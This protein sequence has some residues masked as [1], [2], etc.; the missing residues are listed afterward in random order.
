ME[1]MIRGYSVKQQLNFLQTQY[2]PEVSSRL[3]ATIPVE[4]RAELHDLKAAEWYPRAY[5]IA[6]LRAIASHQGNDEQQV[7]NDLARCGMFIATEA[8]NTFLKLLMKILTPTLFAKKIPEFWK[9][10]QTGGHFEVDTSEAKDGRLK[11]ELCDVEGF[12]HIGVIGIGWISFGLT[13]MGKSNVVVTQKGW[14]L[15]NPGPKNIEYHV[16]WS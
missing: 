9:R 11:L 6:V 7:Y 5:S 12:D 3:F 8:T 10:D 14:A 2:D 13:A 4:I 1:P 15:A 16:R